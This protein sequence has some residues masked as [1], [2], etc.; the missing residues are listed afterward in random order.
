MSVLFVIFLISLVPLPLCYI[1][2]TQQWMQE[3]VVILV[4]GVIVLAL[5][6]LVPC[7]MVR[8]MKNPEFILYVMGLFMFSSMIDL[9][10]ALEA[11]GMIPE[12]MTFYLKDG[13]PYLWT[14][15]GTMINYWDGTVH[16]GLCLWILYA[17]SKRWSYRK[18]GLFWAGSIIN[19][20]LVLVPGSVLGK[21]G[22]KVAILL[23]LP[24]LFVPV[25]IAFRLLK[26]R[27]AQSILNEQHDRPVSIWKRPLDLLFL[28]YF[29]YAAIVDL[30]RG[31]IALGGQEELLLEYL[32]DHEPYIM[33]PYAYPKV[34]LIV[35]MVYFVPYYACAIYGLLN[36]GQTWMPDW[37]LLYAGAAAQGQFSHIGGSIHPR[38]EAEFHVPARAHSQQVFWLLNISLFIIP[39]LFA[40][41]QNLSGK[42]NKMNKKSH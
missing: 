19:S 12:V 16:Y 30:L 37:A 22:I 21:F 25:W 36:P 8:R 32:S 2:N 29:L 9:I 3:P 4:V 5:L 17:I 1:L 41:R 31:F 38:T 27:Q 26:S 11:D 28:I 15:Y 18:V 40:L 6:V 14:P 35:Y 34:Q 24:Y 13:E 7:L 33:S 42:K 10:I 20:L 39:Q 23:N